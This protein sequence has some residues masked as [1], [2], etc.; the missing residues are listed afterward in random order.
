MKLTK[1]TL[2]EIIREV[3]SEGDIWPSKDKYKPTVVLAK[4]SGG[5]RIK[6]FDQQH[7][8]TEHEAKKFIKDM[9]KKYKLK[10]QKGFWA[11]PQTGIELVT[12]F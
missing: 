8:K 10:R 3:I 12:N 6:P 4:Y 5:G 2:R 9:I 1:E 11:N 7:F